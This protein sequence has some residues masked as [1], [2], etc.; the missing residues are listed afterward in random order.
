MA[1]RKSS[2]GQR[3][4]P[5]PRNTVYIYLP[6]DAGNARFEVEEI[7][8]DAGEVID[9]ILEKHGWSPHVDTDLTEDE[10]ILIKVLFA[11][12]RHA[13]VFAGDVS[14][15]LGLSEIDHRVEIR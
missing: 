14:V 12:K 3:G 1:Y 9:G 11:D 2:R 8:E 4:Q 10:E 13:R 5:A 7:I 6:L 15:E